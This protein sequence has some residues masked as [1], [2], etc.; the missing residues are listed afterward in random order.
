MTVDDFLI[1]F[2]TVI[3]IIFEIIFEILKAAALYLLAILLFILIIN[4]KECIEFLRSL[5]DCIISLL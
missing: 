3:G 2:L 5:Y 1:G 4:S